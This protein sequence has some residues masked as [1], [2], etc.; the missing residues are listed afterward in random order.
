MVWQTSPLI[1][2]RRSDAASWYIQ[3]LSSSQKNKDMRMATLAALASLLV[4]FWIPLPSMGKVYIPE[5]ANPSPKPR[6]PIVAIAPK[7]ETP[8]SPTL[9][10]EPKKKI[11]MPPEDKTPFPEPEVRL[12]SLQPEPT[13]T[14]LID[15][16]WEPEGIPD[17]PKLPPMII[18]DGAKGL[19][20]PFFTRRVP[21]NYPHNAQRYGQQGHVILQA[22]LTK[23][24]TIE[25]IEVLRGLG[26]GRM[27]FEKEA[28]KALK[29]WRFLPGTLN[30][31]P[32]DVRMRLKI[33]FVLR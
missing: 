22:V 30:G 14:D 4:L 6:P 31:R 28:I 1:S 17:P 2:D 3:Q 26:D 25:D 11:P 24:G 15:Q 16:D 5:P 32:V 18:D 20:V 23:Q 12:P 7:P 27:G 29:R 10:Q 33:D 19:E 9:K 21:P 13:P 8:Q